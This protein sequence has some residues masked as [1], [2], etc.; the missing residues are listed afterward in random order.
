M[1]FFD[2]SVAIE[3]DY[4]ISLTTVQSSVTF[5]MGGVNDVLV[6]SPPVVSGK[7]VFVMH[8][9]KTLVVGCA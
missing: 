9:N 3:V 6:V 7:H 8:C 5:N 2:N 4:S 1:K